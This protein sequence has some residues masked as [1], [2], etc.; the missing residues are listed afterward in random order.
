MVYQ[1]KAFFLSDTNNFF[2]GI[3]SLLYHNF[4]AIHDIETAR[5]NSELVIVDAY[6]L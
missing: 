2:M 1:T 6:T 5:Q 3:F 4:A